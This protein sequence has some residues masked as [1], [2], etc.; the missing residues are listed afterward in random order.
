MPQYLTVPI[1][2]SKRK[3]RKDDSTSSKRTR[4]DDDSTSIPEDTADVTEDGSLSKLDD[5]A[6]DKREGFASPT[7]TEMMRLTLRELSDRNPK[8]IEPPQEKRILDFLHDAST[9]I[10]RKRHRSSAN[11][12]HRDDRLEMHNMLCDRIRY[13]A[14]DKKTDM[15]ERGFSDAQIETELA[16]KL[17]APYFFS[18]WYMEYLFSQGISPINGNHILP[19]I[20][21]EIHEAMRV[22]EVLDTRR[23]NSDTMDM[24]Y[25]LINLGPSQ[26][27]RGL[28][29]EDFLELCREMV[30]WYIDCK[31]REWR[32]RGLYIEQ[33]GVIEWTS[34]S[35]KLIPERIYVIKNLTK[36][37]TQCYECLPPAQQKKI[38]SVFSLTPEYPVW[39]AESILAGRFQSGD[40]PPE[41]VVE[42][43]PMRWKYPFHMSRIFEFFEMK[44]RILMSYYKIHPVQQKLIYPVISAFPPNPNG[45]NPS[46]KLAVKFDVKV[47][48]RSGKTLKVVHVDVAPY[49]VAAEN[50]LGNTIAIQWYQAT[51]KALGLPK[52]PPQIPPLPDPVA[53]AKAA[54]E[55]VSGL[56]VR[57]RDL[58]DTDFNNVYRDTVAFQGYQ[59]LQKA[60][61]LPELPSRPP[62]VPDPVLSKTAKA[63]LELLQLYTKNTQDPV[64][65]PS[66]KE[67]ST[68]IITD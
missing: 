11:D 44:R 29:H 22:F 51:Q 41:I 43:P 45:P 10:S 60:F 19:L 58:L 64:Q 24:I 37:M 26:V 31:G 12:Q 32:E 49:N 30:M 42:I 48:P 40:E 66:S 21:A 39:N 50:A 36:L 65:G 53:S 14:R 46:R 5:R 56:I 33:N 7:T 13:W 47:D 6:I 38:Y 20:K 27:S 35:S 2:S 54:L 57:I 1:R 59:V 34:Q 4:R 63:A 16:K 23:T 52:L 9:S 8:F 68:I 17:N 28:I 61:G 67:S 15:R 3:R 25:E 18:W 55:N 62:P